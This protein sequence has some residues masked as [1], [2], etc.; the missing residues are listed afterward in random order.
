[1]AC[2]CSESR[3]GSDRRH[4]CQGE[5]GCN[6]KPPRQVFARTAQCAELRSNVEVGPWWWCCCGERRRETQRARDCA[7]LP[8]SVVSERDAQGCRRADDQHRG[9]RAIN[10]CL[11]TQIVDSLQDICQV[12]KVSVPA[13]EGGLV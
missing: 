6:C 12:R 9:A 11:V 3:Y 1:A 5:E 8:A 13:K 7:A 10:D 4:H 2:E